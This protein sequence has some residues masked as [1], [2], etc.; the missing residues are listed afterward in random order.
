MIEIWNPKKCVEIIYKWYFFYSAVNPVVWIND[1]L[2]SIH[3]NFWKFLKVC[4]D[5]KND[6]MCRIWDWVLY[7]YLLDV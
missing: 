5:I 2:W 1:Y 4:L 6:Y 7:I 3:A